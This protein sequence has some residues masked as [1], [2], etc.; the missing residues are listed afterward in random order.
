MSLY[1][2]PERHHK[3][4]QYTH[5]LAPEEMEILMFCY[6]TL[7]PP[8]PRKGSGPAAQFTRLLRDVTPSCPKWSNPWILR[9]CPLPFPRRS[10]IEALLSVASGMPIKRFIT[11]RMRRGGKKA[12]VHLHL[13]SVGLKAEP[14][15]LNGESIWAT[16]PL[17]PCSYPGEAER[18]WSA[19][20]F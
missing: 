5:S 16:P 4:P 9:R 19:C 20:P 2:R 8:D 15:L 11:R 13:G 17:G 10:R 18:Q 1:V 3:L 12:F 6:P 7:R 14:Q